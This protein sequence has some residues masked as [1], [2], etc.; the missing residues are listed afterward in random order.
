MPA[1]QQL[2]GGGA[3]KVRRRAL[4]VAT[5]AGCARLEGAL[6]SFSSRAGAGGGLRH[7]AAGRTS[8]AMPTRAPGCWLETQ[9]GADPSLIAWQFERAEDTRDAFRWYEAAA[10]IALRAARC[11]AH[12]PAPRSRARLPSARARSK[13]ACSSSAPRPTF[14]RH[15]PVDGALAA[16]RALAHERRRV[17]HTWVTAVGDADRRGGERR[18]DSEQVERLADMLRAACS[19]RGCGVVTACGPRSAAPLRSCS[20]WPRPDGAIARCARV[21]DRDGWNNG[22]DLG[23]PLVRAWLARLQ[24]RLRDASNSRYE[25]GIVATQATA[26]RFFATAGDGRGCLPGADLPGVAAHPHRPTSPPLPPSSTSPSRWRAAR[27]PSYLAS[28]ASYAR[29]KIL[30]LAGDA[31]VAHEHLVQVRGTAGGAPADDR[32]DARVLGARRAAQRRR[33]AWAEKEGTRCAR[34]SRAGCGCARSRSRRCSRAR[35]WP[36]ATCRRRRGPS[37]ARRLRL[38]TA[39]TGG[40]RRERGGGA[41]RRLR[42]GRSRA[43]QRRRGAGCELAI[44]LDVLTTV[45]RNVLDRPRAGSD[46]FTRSTHTVRCCSSLSGSA[47]AWSTCDAHGARY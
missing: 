35:S 41:P 20:A 12:P 16:T 38:L 44:A 24:G 2:G 25:S 21:A 32:R 42:D 39:R 26:V 19:A 4:R 18:G 29:G 34:L 22:Q 7:A 31:V 17:A 5:R 45:A 1:R 47:S 33:G 10:R 36:E 30:A 15:Q 8:D 3:A 9:P 23:E 14:L 43:G 40:S 13:R 28:W 27:E 46:F 11:P 37:R 6:R